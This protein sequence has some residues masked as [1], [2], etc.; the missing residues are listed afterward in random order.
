MY[1]FFSFPFR[2]ITL[3]CIYSKIVQT[4][5]YIKYPKEKKKKIH[6]ILKKNAKRKQRTSN[7]NL[8]EVEM[9]IATAE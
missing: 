9:K 7:M 3:Q 5:E 8:I 1:K 6:S 2:I 4:I